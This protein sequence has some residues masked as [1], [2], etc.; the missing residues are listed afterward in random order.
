VGGRLT[1]GDED[2]NYKAGRGEAKWLADEKVEEGADAK[3]HRRRGPH[4]V[5]DTVGRGREMAH[6]EGKG[7]SGS[8]W[9]SRLP[10]SRK[11]FK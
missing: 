5:S 11:R 3:G 6:M 4:K 7:P 9:V 8:W 2:A 10:G 1:V